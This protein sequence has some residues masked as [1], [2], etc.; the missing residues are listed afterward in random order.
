MDSTGKIAKKILS[1]SDVVFLVYAIKR[2]NT[3]PSK[4]QKS[5]YAFIISPIMLVLGWR[6]HDYIAS[7]YRNFLI[8]FCFPDIKSI[9]GHAYDDCNTHKRL[10]NVPLSTSCCQ[11]SKEYI[12]VTLRRAFSLYF[13]FYLVQLVIVSLLKR[14]FSQRQVQQTLLS[15]IRSSLFLGGQTIVMRLTLCAANSGLGMKLNFFN[16]FLMGYLGS[17]CIWIERTDRVGQINNL[18]FSHILIGWLKKKNLLHPLLSLPIFI[19]TIRRDKKV[20]P[21]TLLIAMGST[22]TF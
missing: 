15:I 16:V 1:N 6:W 13:R 5:M 3:I 22:L 4:Y 20:D 21:I 14:K 17:L 18:V 2:W 12:P 7:G 10:A 19:A 11:L 8:K 9:A